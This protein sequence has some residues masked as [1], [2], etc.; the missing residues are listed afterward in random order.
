MKKIVLIIVSILLVGILAISFASCGSKDKDLSGD[1]TG[2]TIKVA[3]PEG[4]PALA[5]CHMVT[6]NTTL[7][8]ATMEYKAVAPALIAAE[9]ASG[10]SDIVIMPINA[11]AKKIIDG[12]NYKLVSI[13][14]DGSLYMIGKKDVAGAIT[15]DDIKGKKIASIGQGAV[16]GLTLEYVL[17]SNNINVIYE[18][19]PGANDVFIQYVADGPSARAALQNNS[20]N[21][22][23]VGEPAAT[24]F[25]N[26]AAL[27]LNAEMDIQ[28]EYGKLAG[29]TTYPQAGLFVKASLASNTEFMNKLFEALAAS[30]SWV[31]S[32]KADVTS[33][34]QAN[35]YSTANFPAA[36]IDRCAI[37]ATALTAS[38]KTAII[39]FLKRIMP[40][41]QWDNNTDK[42]F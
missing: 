38:D 21:F 31:T 40:A 11:G 12:A 30:K 39:S 41:V 14:V 32:N 28:A 16:P 6:E 15:M 36:A 5:I 27:G 3:A 2:E 18:G 4:T 7:F 22:A 1:L 19:T 10:N 34:V 37:N 13:A 17:K 20:V 33:Y 42:I 25:K 26:V 8:G 23:V 9:L 35:L 24:T 29:V